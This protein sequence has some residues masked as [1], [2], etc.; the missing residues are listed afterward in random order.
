MPYIL[1]APYLL[2]RSI[3]LCGTACCTQVYDSFTLPSLTFA[4]IVDDKKDFGAL[5]YLNTNLADT[6]RGPMKKG[7]FLTCGCTGTRKRQP[8]PRACPHARR[9]TTTHGG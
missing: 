8:C 4:A 9:H 6:W 2:Q 7:T 5:Q 3:V 1:H